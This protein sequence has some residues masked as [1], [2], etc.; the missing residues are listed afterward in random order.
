MF[1]LGSQEII[2]ILLVILVL[3]G[4]KKIPEMMAGLGKGIREF[5][6]A[7]K[8]VHAL[9]G[10]NLTCS[11]KI[12]ENFESL[13]TAAAVQRLLEAD[14]IIIGKTN[15]DEFAMG[16]SN[17]NSAYGVVKNPFDNSRVPGGSSGGSAV[18]VA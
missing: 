15:C 8:D 13:Y 3:F 5:K 16:S 11:S 4:A 1:G 7:T 2:L 14:A 10:K 17:E 18:A 6:K 12:L 9:K